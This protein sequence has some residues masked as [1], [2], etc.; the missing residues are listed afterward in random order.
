M[1][2]IAYRDGVMA[3]DTKCGYGPTPFGDLCKISR[4]R[5]GD[6]AGA[7]GEALYNHKFQQWFLKNRGKPPSAR[8]NPDNMEETLIVPAGWHNACLSVEDRELVVFNGP[9]FAIGSGR[10]VAMGALHAGAS[11]IE[12]VKAAI[13]YDEGCGGDIWWASHDQPLTIIQQNVTWRK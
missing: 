12:A 6:L 2:C 10:R 5:N 11:A 1:T 4:R 13:A 3:C 9:H 7:A 8:R